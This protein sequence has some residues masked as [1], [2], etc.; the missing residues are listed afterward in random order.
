MAVVTDWWHEKTLD[1][2]DPEQ[3]DALCDG[4]GRCCLH[5][6]EDSETGELSYTRVRCRL[7]D[8]QSCRCTHYARRSELVPDCVRLHADISEELAWLPP[9]CAYRL[10]AEHKPLPSWHYLVSGSSDSVHQAG[11]SVRGQSISEEHVHPEGYDEYIVTWA[12]G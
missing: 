7:L 10:R 11:I 8:Q 5:K 6:L 2:L 4:C 3:W 12:E 9:T 1:E